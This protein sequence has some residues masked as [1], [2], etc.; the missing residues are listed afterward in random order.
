MASVMYTVVRMS[1]RKGAPRKAIPAA[2][3]VQPSSDDVHEIV[4]FQRHKKDDA[5]ERIPGREFMQ[6]CPQGLALK[7]SA[8]LT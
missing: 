6:R 8:I 4:Y 1:S 3:R 7:L 5:I 2:V